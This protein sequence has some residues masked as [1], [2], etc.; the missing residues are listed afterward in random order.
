MPEQPALHCL[1]PASQSPD[2]YGPRMVE[3]LRAGGRTIALHALPGDYPGVDQSAILAADIVVSR[4]PD[5]ALVLVDGLALPGVAAALSIDNRR[6]RLVALVGGLLWRDPALD[7]GAAAARRNLEQGTLALMRA[8][9]VPSDALAAEVAALG[10]PPA[11][12][13]VA[14]PDAGGIARL[15]AALPA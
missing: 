5:G 14:P 8:V 12:V 15:I 9:A 1:I 4:L 6:V 10:L 13:S 2:A 11:R 7:A 3:A